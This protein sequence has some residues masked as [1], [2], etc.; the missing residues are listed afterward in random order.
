MDNIAISVQQVSKVFQI[1]ETP[2]DRLKQFLSAN[3]SRRFGR[4]AKQYYKEFWALKDV[5]FTVKQGE[6]IGIIGQNGSGKSTLL[7][8]ICGTLAPSSGHIQTHG[9]IA[10]LLELGSGFNPEFTGRD[11]VF[12]NATLL[13]LKQAEIIERYDDIARFADIGDFIDQ[14]V[15]TYSSGMMVRLAFA[16][17]INVNPQILIVDEALSVGDE[18][19]QRKCFAK[20]ESLKAD[21][22]TILFVSHS[23]ATV[24]ELCDRAVL[25]DAGENIAIG[26]PKPVVGKYQKLIYAPL[27]K[28]A[29]IR[30]EIN[31]STRMHEMAYQTVDASPSN[32]VDVALHDDFSKAQF[33]LN[34]KPTTTIAYES[35]GAIIEHPEILTMSGEQVN[36]LIK[37]QS[38]YF[39]YQV[40]FDQTAS[41]VSFGMLI[42]T[43]SGLEI[44]GFVS[45]H[46]Y[47]GGVSVVK[48]GNMMKV[49]FR[50]E[51]LLN[52]GT[53][54]LNAGVQGAVNT[55]KTFLHRILDIYMFRV[56]PVSKNS[57]TGIVDF[58]CTVDVNA[59]N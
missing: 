55:E 16:V 26:S 40:R 28:R 56:M 33:D 8:L 48:N 17:A 50:F 35:H 34:L 24:V 4:P 54:F 3:I 2:K 37:G 1:Y 18:T 22:A 41:N 12:M 9:R 36:C 44:G 30:A 19:F 49:E 51:C 45:N 43:L 7:Q 58:N 6:T 53:Y 27:D 21:G 57:V 25:L 14:P 15:K 13:G 38:Y 11:N 52:P 5:S 32:A 59:I 10:A 42:K 31:A 23:A 46:A 39:N 20:I 29:E 47:D